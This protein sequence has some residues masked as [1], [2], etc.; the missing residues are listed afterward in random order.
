MGKGRERG[1]GKKSRRTIFL[2]AVPAM[3]VAWSGKAGYGMVWY[4]MVLT[5]DDLASP[6]QPREGFVS[7]SF[8]FFFATDYVTHGPAA[9]RMFAMCFY[10]ILFFSTCVFVVVVV[11]QCSAVIVGSVCMYCLCRVD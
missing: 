2:A 11:V 1:K 3:F 8:F 6:A 7:P 5:A 4:G 9:M 10:T